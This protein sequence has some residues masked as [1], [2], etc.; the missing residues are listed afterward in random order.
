MRIDRCRHDYHGAVGFVWSGRDFAAPV[1]NA[2]R[3][4]VGIAKEKNKKKVEDT[5]Y[6]RYS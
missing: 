3:P 4:A 1:H 2:K 5:S 6:L